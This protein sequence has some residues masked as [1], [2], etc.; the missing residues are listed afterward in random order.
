MDRKDLGKILIIISIIGL[1]FTV[2]ISSFTLITLNN[3]YEKALPL[4]DKIDVMKNYIN[5]FDENLDEFDTYLKDIDTDY[6]LQKLSD[7]RSFANTLN[8][9]GLGSLVS[10][11]NEDIAKVEIIITNIEE[12]KLNFDF[13]KRDFSNIK[14]SLSE[15]D[16]LKENII[17]FIGLLRTYIIATATYGILISGLLLYAGYY[18]LNLNKL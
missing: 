18:I 2:S 4:F 6:Y 13:A 17:S 7:I 1:I 12:L 16:I 8:S 14:A 5:T 15:Y 3:T 10:G 9:F 11:F